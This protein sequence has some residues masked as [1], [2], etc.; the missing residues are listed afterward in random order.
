MGWTQNHVR[1][2][3]SNCSLSN[4]GALTRPEPTLSPSACPPSCP[5]RIL[6]GPSAHPIPRG[7]PD[8]PC[9]C[10]PTLPQDTVPRVGPSRTQIS[11]EGLRRCSIPSTFQGTAPQQDSRP[12]EGTPGTCQNPTKLKAF[13]FSCTTAT[14]LIDRGVRP[15]PRE[16][17]TALSAIPSPSEPS[18]PTGGSPSPRCFLDSPTAESV[19]SQGAAC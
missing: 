8:G 5:L 3:G 6:P 13:Q 19:A 16:G 9:R 17:S 15:N 18:V 11:L 1:P 10:V 14:P 12:L 2:E 7:S 4:S